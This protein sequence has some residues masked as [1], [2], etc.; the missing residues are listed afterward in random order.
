M[1]QFCTSGPEEGRNATV[2]GYNSVDQLGVL[3]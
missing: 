2:Y 3:V 1:M